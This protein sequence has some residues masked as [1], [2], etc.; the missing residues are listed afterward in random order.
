M[1]NPPLPNM[2]DAPVFT[3]NYENDTKEVHD[4]TGVITAFKEKAWAIQTIDTA[5]ADTA[6]GEKKTADAFRVS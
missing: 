3:G 6:A 2:P 4:F 1:A 5:W